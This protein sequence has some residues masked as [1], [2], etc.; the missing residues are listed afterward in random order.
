LSCWILLSFSSTTAGTTGNGAAARSSAATPGA[1]KSRHAA[2]IHA[3]RL[4]LAGGTALIPGMVAKWGPSSTEEDEDEDDDED[5]DEDDDEDE[6]EDEDFDCADD[7]DDDDDDDADD[8]DNA[9]EGGRDCDG[10]PATDFFKDS[11]SADAA[12]SPGPLSPAKFQ[13]RGS[14]EP[15]SMSTLSRLASLPLLPW[16]L[17][18]P[19]MC[20]T[21][22]EVSS[23]AAAMCRSAA[24]MLIRLR[25]SRCRAMKLCTAGWSAAPGRDASTS[26]ESAG[27]VGSGG[28]SSTYTASRTRA[29]ASHSRESG[30]IATAHDSQF[31]VALGQGGGRGRLRIW[32]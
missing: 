24:S 12:S 25:R 19:C 8:D 3:R 32:Q 7:D 10:D 14:F 15:S 20:S 31:D 2:V 13:F 16:A 6:D 11:D 28:P 30:A 1:V 29:Q 5:E 22:S 27:A 23:P 18:S 4:A 17:R 26:G 21:S 9:G